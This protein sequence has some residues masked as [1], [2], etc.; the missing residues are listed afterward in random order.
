MSYSSWKRIIGRCKYRNKRIYNYYHDI[1]YEIGQTYSEKDAN[2]DETIQC[3]AGISL[4]SMDW[5]LKEYKEGYRIF[6]AEFTR[7]DIACIPIGSD[8][9]FRVKR[10]KIVAEKDLRKLNIGI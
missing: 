2:C 10:C 7:E 8:G 6:V 4:A 1:K 9:K 5:C 3:A